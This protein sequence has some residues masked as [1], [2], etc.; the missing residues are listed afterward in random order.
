MHLLPHEVDKLL[1]TQ[2]GLLAQRRLSRGLRLN[3]PEST[4]LIAH[5]L[6]E[7]IRDGS[8]TVAELMSLGRSILGLREV[9]DGV[10]WMM[11]EV[12]VEGTFVDGTKLV[13]VHEP[14][15]RDRGDLRLA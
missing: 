11:K 13:T 15:V 5:V 4:A 3:L 6:L 10:A 14:I 7:L 2:C 1:I 8:H 9:M 12:Q